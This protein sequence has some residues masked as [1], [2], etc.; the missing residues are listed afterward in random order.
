MLMPAMWVTNPLIESVVGW[1]VSPL[2]ISPLLAAGIV[3]NT[4]ER[5]RILGLSIEPAAN[6][7]MSAVNSLG[8]FA[9]VSVTASL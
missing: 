9:R 6:T 4:G 2:P 5:L 7:T 8:W 1:S 3:L